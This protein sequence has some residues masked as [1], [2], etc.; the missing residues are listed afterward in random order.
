MRIF[1]GKEYR[2]LTPEELAEMEKQKQQTEH[3]Y[4]ANISYDEAV[5][6]EIAKKYTIK[7]E[8]AIQR[9]QIKK[10]E[11]F[12][13]YDAYCEQCKEYVK[14]KQLEAKEYLQQ[15]GVTNENDFSI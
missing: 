1:D 8:L 9:Q 13:I 3:E 7:Q 5:E 2:D 12:A 6:N 11:E 15:G 10:P 4:W 14:Q